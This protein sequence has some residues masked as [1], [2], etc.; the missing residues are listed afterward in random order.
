[1]QTVLLVLGNNRTEKRVVEAAVE[2]AKS[3]GNELVVLSPLDPGR[4][5]KIVGKVIDS[6]T[7]GARPSDDF[8][9]S[10]HKRHEDLAVAQAEEAVAEA[11][12]CGVSAHADVRRGGFREK[13]TE[14]VTTLKPAAVV[15][16]KRKRGWLP[17]A[18]EHA[19]LDKLRKDLGFELIER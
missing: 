17:F 16:T 7:L 3:G 8:L 15:I 18:Y 9:S 12:R 6:G 11:A 1:M 4:Q 10:L 13:V 5:T 14:V 2:R 19:F